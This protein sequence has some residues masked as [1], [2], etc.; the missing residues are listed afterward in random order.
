MAIVAVL[1]SGTTRASLNDI[2]TS[3]GNTQSAWTS[4]N[5]T[6]TSQADFNSDILNYVDA[7]SSGGVQLTRGPF[8]FRGNGTNVTWEY[9]PLANSWTV[10]TAAPGN[11]GAGSTTGGSLAYEGGNYVY[12]LQGGST[13]FWRYDVLA[14]NWTTLATVPLAIAAGGA[15]AYVNSKTI[16]ALRGGSTTFYS[17]NI[18]TNVWST[19]AT[20]PNAIAAGGSLAYDD[21]NNVYALRGNSNAFYSYHLSTNTWSTNATT[22]ANVN[23]GA[24]LVYVSA[25]NSVFALRGNNTTAF[26]RFN[27]PLNTWTTITSAPGNIGTGASM[28]YDGNNSIYVFQGGGVNSTFYRFNLSPGTWSTLTTAPGTVG[29]GGSLSDMIAKGRVTST[30]SSN[31]TGSRWDAIFWDQSLPVSTNITF[32]V[33]ASDT[34]FLPTASNVTLPWISIGNA[35]SSTTGYVISG[36]PSGKYKQWRATLSTTNVI[37]TPVLNEV[38]VYYFGG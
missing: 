34:V 9:E 19:N 8:A 10:H 26:Y 7:L 2:E 5:W 32:E 3:T 28:A 24:A 16:Y 17:Y 29:A 37:R 31:V 35:G 20:T 12:A 38:R 22:P 36:L 33:R 15:L 4:A 18:S 23:A 11:V 27:I 14:D 1:V 21:G 30:V 6:Q 25:N 13:T